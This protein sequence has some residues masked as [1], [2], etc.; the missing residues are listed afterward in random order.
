MIGTI[1]KAEFRNM[2]RDRMYAFFAVYPAIFGTMGYFLVKW[3]EDK[4]PGGVAG[5]IT[6][7]MLIVVTGY[8]FGALIAFTLLD[9]KDDKVLM[10]LK[11]T[12]I[13]V[14][15]YIYVKMAAGMIFGFVATLILLLA[16]NFLPNANFF[17]LIGVALLGAIQV[18][19]V[20]LIVNSF[21]DNKVEG[22][23]VMKLSGMVLMFPVIGFLV[24]GW[25]QYLLGVAPG[26]WAGS[27]IEVELGVDT[28]STVLLFFAGIV[29]NLF[30]TWLLMKFYTKRSNI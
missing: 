3:F 5:P 12:P 2:F 8:V 27:L 28:G 29:Y 14:K 1:I 6:A 7:M 23:V 17:V 24:A 9:D 15:H 4:Y 18:P 25:A 16:T 19:S 21:S 26:Y 22:F 30:A 20:T 13:N 10:S 11:I